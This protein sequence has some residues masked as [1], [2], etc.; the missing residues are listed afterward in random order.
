MSHE[1]N[2]RVFLGSLAVAPVALPMAVKA[3]ATD[4]PL[5]VG[6]DLGSAEMMSYVAMIAREINNLPL[7][8]RCGHFP[9]RHLLSTDDDAR[10][11][12]L[13]RPRSPLSPEPNLTSTTQ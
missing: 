1:M 7:T 9:L 11:M 13:N 4:V 10:V 3:A 5:Y 2:R 6:I 12:A 8:I